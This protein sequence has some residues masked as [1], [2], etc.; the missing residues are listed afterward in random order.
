MKYKK[1]FWFFNK[2][3]DLARKYCFLNE[4]DFLEAI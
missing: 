4:M 1:G 2:V 3:Y